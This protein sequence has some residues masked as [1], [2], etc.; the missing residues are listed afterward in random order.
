MW[1]TKGFVKVTVQSIV[2]V[3]GSGGSRRSLRGG[4]WLPWA[5]TNGD[6]AR[7]AAPAERSYSRSFF[8]RVSS[9]LSSS[10]TIVSSP[11]ESSSRGYRGTNSEKRER[12]KK[13]RTAR[14]Y[15]HDGQVALGFGDMTDTDARETDNRQT[16]RRTAGRRTRQTDRQTGRQID[17][18]IDREI[19]IVNN[20]RFSVI[21]CCLFKTNFSFVLRGSSV[22]IHSTLHPDSS[23]YPSF[24][25]SVDYRR[26]SSTHRYSDRNDSQRIANDNK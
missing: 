3:G 9:F 2:C 21:R 11:K 24:V 6:A 8:Q 13:K 4:K 18:Q 14:Q 22:S 5:L 12:K 15:G 7:S 1:C 23:L 17:K 10:I 19:G 26:T 25:R 20:G 16:G